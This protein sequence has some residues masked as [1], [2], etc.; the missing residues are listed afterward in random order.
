MFFFHAKKLRH[1]GLHAQ[2]VG[3]CGEDTADDGF[4]ESFEA[5]ATESADSEGL[6]AFVVVAGTRRDEV[7]FEDTKFSGGA[8]DR[9]GEDCAHASWLHEGESVWDGYQ[10][11]FA[12][13]LGDAKVFFG[14]D[15]FGFEIHFANEIEGVG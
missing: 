9:S 2:L 7:F 1:G 15:E 4:D 8:E 6:D 10:F 11:S 12:D 13:D 3:F 14:C 5:F